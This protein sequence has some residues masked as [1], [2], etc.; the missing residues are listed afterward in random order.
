MTIQ[1]VENFTVFFQGKMVQ[2][3]LLEKTNPESFRGN[4]MAVA[5]LAGFGVAK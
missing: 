4:R 3:K 5:R 2:R 1:N